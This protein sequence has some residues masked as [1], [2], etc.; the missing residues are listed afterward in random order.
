M[1]SRREGGLG[2]REISALSEGEDSHSPTVHYFGCVTFASVTR[3]ITDEEFYRWRGISMEVV[4]LI[5]FNIFIFFFSF[6][7]YPVQP[8]DNG[9]ILC[10]LHYHQAL[11]GCTK[12]TGNR[13][14]WL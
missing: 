8:W 6:L 3:C 10:L 11:D 1:Y 5:F 13:I 14:R 2:W 12:A 7:H 9:I 4:Y